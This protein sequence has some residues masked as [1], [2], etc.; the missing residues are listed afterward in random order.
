MLT[1]WMA[2]SVYVMLPFD[3]WVPMEISATTVAHVTNLVPYITSLLTTIVAIV[4]IIFG[5]LSSKDAVAGQWRQEIWKKRS[6]VY[7]EIVRMTDKQDPM[8]RPTAEG[9]QEEAER[10]D[11]KIKFYAV[12]ITSDEWHEFIYMIE[13]YSSDEVHQLFCLWE[14]LWQNWSFSMAFAMVRGEGHEKRQKDLEESYEPVNT[15]RQRLVDH[16]RA[17]L[18]FERKPMP[19]V[20]YRKH[21]VEFFGLIKDVRFDRINS[22]DES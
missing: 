22:K 16:I 11:G 14:R 19:K 8:N 10:N 18:N 21:P 4:A 3:K 13:T 7:L 20:F 15:A 6:E 2:C 9:F 5:R 17:E 12:D 1:V